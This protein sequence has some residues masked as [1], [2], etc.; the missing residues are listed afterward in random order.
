MLS[1]S[2]SKPNKKDFKESTDWISRWVL[3]KKIGWPVLILLVF[4]DAFIT[5]QAGSESNPLWRPLAEKFGLNFLW[6]A[7]LIVLAIFFAAT[8]IFGRIVEKTEHFSRGEEFILTNLVIV[9]ATYDLYIAFLVPRIGYL[10]TSTHYAIIPVLFIPILA[11]NVF[12]EL[13]KR[14]SLKQI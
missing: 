11:Y 14:K 9:F 13:Q 5:I 2:V 7:A 12:V 10:G 4:F 3:P 6:A 1:E 8:K